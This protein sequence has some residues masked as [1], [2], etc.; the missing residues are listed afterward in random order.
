MH[1]HNLALLVTVAVVKKQFL[2][3]VV[4]N[5]QDPD[6]PVLEFSLGECGDA[7]VNFSLLFNCL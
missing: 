7:E 2:C 6:E 5:S 3:V 1:V 4:G